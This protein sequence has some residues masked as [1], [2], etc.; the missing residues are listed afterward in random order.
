M[1]A[2]CQCGCGEPAPL[3]TRTNRRRG[4]IK[5][6]PQRFIAKHHNAQISRAHHGTPDQEAI[7]TPG[8]LPTPCLIWQRCVNSRG[9]GVRGVGDRRVLAHRAAYEAAYGPIPAGHQVHHRCETPLCV[10]PTHLEAVTALQHKQ[11][12]RVLRR[13]A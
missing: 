4:Q 5:G 8:P 10:E 2:L 9:Y 7:A 3:F 1:T 13:A 12:H 11:R 6:Q